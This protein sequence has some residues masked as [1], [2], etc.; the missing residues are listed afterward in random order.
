M[1]LCVFGGGCGCALGCSLRILTLRYSFGAVFFI[2]SSFYLYCCIFDSLLQGISRA[3]DLFIIFFKWTCCLSIKFEIFKKLLSQFNI[4]RF[5]VLKQT[6][7]ICW[8]SRNGCLG[9]H[10]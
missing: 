3:F 6:T 10:T 4:N 5:S 7:L 9:L 1:H 2:I 8:I